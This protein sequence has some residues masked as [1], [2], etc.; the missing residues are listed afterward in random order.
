MTDAEKLVNIAGNVPNVYKNG[1]DVG[2]AAGQEAGGGGG[3]EPIIETLTIT[4]NGTYTA[5]DGVDG[6]SPVTVNVPDLWDLLQ[7]YGNRTDYTYGFA[8]HL[9]TNKTFKPKYTIRPTEAGRMFM[10][11]L[12]TDISGV[13]IDFSGA[14]GN[15]I[16][17]FDASSITKVGTVDLSNV[18]GTS[19]TFFGYT[20]GNPSKLETI[21]LLIIPADGSMTMGS[22]FFQNCSALANIT[23]SGQIATSINMQWCTSLTVDSMKS[24]ILA[25]KDFDGNGGTI[26]GAWTQTITF[27]DECWT[28]L[29]ADGTF[30]P[31]GENWKSYVENKLAWNV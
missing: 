30:A 27:P 7:D 3:A 14:T 1:Y 21:G 5:P 10:Y 24:I 20:E 4:K 18:K 2:Y 26:E 31:N 16:R 9:W 12:M 25:L 15:I 6:Y 8:G 22:N 23:I 19:N 13:D 29:E 28:A 11:S 17:P